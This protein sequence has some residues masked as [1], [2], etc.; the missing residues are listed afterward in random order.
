MKRWFAAIL[1][2][3][4]DS[5][6][7]KLINMAIQAE[8]EDIANQMVLAKTKELDTRTSNIT[9]NLSDADILLGELDKLENQFWNPT[10][11]AL[12]MFASGEL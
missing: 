8:S 7:F 2:Q 11:M 12:E 3:Y 10:P 9:I 1:C 5:P 6:E 4:Q